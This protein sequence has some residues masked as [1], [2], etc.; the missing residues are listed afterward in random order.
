M[1]IICLKETNLYFKKHLNYCIRICKYLGVM[2]LLYLFANSTPIIYSKNLSI[3]FY[4]QNIT[5][6]LSGK[7]LQIFHQSNQNIP[8][9][10]KKVDDPPVFLQLA[11]EGIYFWKIPTNFQFITISGEFA[12]IKK[13]DFSTGINEII[14]I[15]LGGI[16]NNESY[17]VEIYSSSKSKTTL[18]VKGNRFYLERTEEDLYLI[19]KPHTL[20]G[21]NSQKHNIK[22]LSLTVKKKAH[23]F[24]KIEKNHSKSQILFEENKEYNQSIDEPLLEENALEEF[25]NFSSKSEKLDSGNSNSFKPY[26]HSWGKKKPI[27]GYFHLNLINIIENYTIYYRK[28]IFES[29]NTQGVAIGVGLGFIPNRF[30]RIT[31]YIDGYEVNSEVSG[32]ETNDRVPTG[33]YKRMN[34]EFQLGFDTLSFTNK[35]EN[36]SL[37]LT[38][39]SLYSQFPVS[40]GNTTTFYTGTGLGYLYYLKNH[41]IELQILG[42]IDAKINKSGILRSEYRYLWNSNIS[43]SLGFFARSLER[44]EDDT[45]T[46]FKIYNTTIGVRY[47]LQD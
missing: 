6:S 1:K 44:K 4:S 45:R 23:P 14:Q 13:K 36:H 30:W 28:S 25:S 34:V 17:L 8:I 18:L 29:P 41:I 12:A 27:H 38:F 33:I 10:E 35:L 16:R 43:F 2:S 37:H 31:S 47:S 5:K 42:A 39:L 20:V 7:K 32:F 22:L 11:N 9:L 19:V 3:P 15:D 46:V 21:I 24:M 26:W 40:K